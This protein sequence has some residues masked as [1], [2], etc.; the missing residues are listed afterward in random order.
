MSSIIKIETDLLLKFKFRLN[1]KSPQYWIDMLTFLWDDYINKQVSWEE[2]LYFRE[3]DSTVNISHLL[4]MLE[5]TYLS[6]D[7][8][9]FPTSTIILAI[10]YLII[11]IKL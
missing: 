4:Q 5:K 3:N 2:V 6:L 7:V 10:M 9:Q 1:V 11:R 8:Y